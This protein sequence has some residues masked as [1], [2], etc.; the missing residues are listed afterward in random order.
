MM[1]SVGHYAR[2]ELLS[3]LHDDRPASFVHQPVRSPSDTPGAS[4]MSSSPLLTNEPPCPPVVMGL[5][6]MPTER[7]INAL[8]SYGLGW[9]TAAPERR[10]AA[11]A[12][13]P[14]TTRR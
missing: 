6:G 13:A 11:A 2:P 3:L 1:D 12:P 7:L 5:V 9:P 14:P 10:A 4:T 8:Q